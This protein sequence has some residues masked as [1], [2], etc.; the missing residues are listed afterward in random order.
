MSSKIQ[1]HPINLTRDLSSPLKDRD[2][3]RKNV[4]IKV[5]PYFR[6]VLIGEAGNVRYHVPLISLIIHKDLRDQFL[7]Y[8]QKNQT[9]SMAKLRS[10]LLDEENLE[11]IVQVI[12]KKI[13]TACKVNGISDF[14]YKSFVYT[15][16][17]YLQGG[18]REEYHLSLAGI[19][20]DDPDIIDLTPYYNALEVKAKQK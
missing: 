20:S 17:N 10:I 3:A 8:T 13:A 4:N 6:R 19:V 7:S 11:K 14:D 12:A 16:T 9:P 1:R 5:E 2:D 18:K 15:K